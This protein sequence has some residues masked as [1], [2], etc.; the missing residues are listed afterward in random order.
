MNVNLFGAAA[1]AAPKKPLFGATP[2]ASAP[3]PTTSAKPLFSPAPAQ[4][5]VTLTPIAATPPAIQPLTLTSLSTAQKA[6][7]AALP[8]PAAA[9]FQHVL[10]VVANPS[11]Q[12]QLAE[13]LEK[14]ALAQTDGEKT[15]AEHLQALTD[16]KRASGI[17]GGQL[18]RELVS[19]LAQ[20]DK[21]TVYQGLDKYTCAATNLERQLAEKPAAL[22]GLVEGLS[23]ESG[24]A[25]LG[26]FPQLQR[27]PGSLTEDSSGRNT[28]NRL[29]Q[30]AFMSF[31][32][33]LHGGYDAAADTYGDGTS[34]GVK[35]LE[36]ALMTACADGANH[37]VV[38][39][40]GGTHA[41]FEKVVRAA[42]Q[43]QN[44]QLGVS[45]KGQDHMILFKGRE[46]EDAH[47]FDPQAGT[48]GTMPLKDLLF[49]S[50]MG[51]FPESLLQGT[52]F[53]S[54]AVYWPTSQQ[55]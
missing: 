1:P 46:G 53:P 26:K 35:P 13:L 47:Y 3:A 15:T 30:G 48:G 9:A 28:L 54:D 25:Q 16:K 5:V 4:D 33:Q 8:G 39:H 31:V 50:Q 24:R 29:V 19:T 55:S 22:A 45:W 52:E 2:T 14:G 7:F 43:G 32:G 10:N 21:E 27:A 42:Q 40:D 20:P 34:P 12:Q 44:F 17:D 51:I 18:T 36:I 6:A 38:V 49:K 41:E 11:S 23:N 37:A